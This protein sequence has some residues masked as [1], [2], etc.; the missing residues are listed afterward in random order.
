ML[1][2]QLLN[3]AIAAL[4]VVG[5]L[6]AA[7]D[8]PL[9][10]SRTRRAICTP[11]AGGTPTTD[12]VP[13]I[14]SALSTCGGGG[15]IVLPAD[16]TYH[17]NSVLDLSACAGCDIQIEGV[18]QF[19]SD[20]S[21]WSGRTAMI[22]L[23][24][25][26]GAQIRSATGS[27]V[28]DGAGQEAWDLFATNSSYARP[29]LLY[30][31]GGA[32]I[33]VRGLQLKDAPNVFVSINGGA[34]RVA[35][36]ELRL[37]AASNSTNAPKNTDG[38]DVGASTGVTLRDIDIVNDDDCVAFKP[39]ADYA[40]VE[41]ITCTGSHGISVGSLGKTNADAVT[42]VYAGNVTM[43]NSTKAAGIKTYPG[44]ASHGSAVV[45]NVTF[46]GFTVQ[47]C[48]YAFQVQSCYG[49]EEEYCQ[50]NPA[51]AQI[52]EVVVKDFSGT[53]SSKYDPTT[54]NINC[55]ADGTCGITVSGWNVKTPSGRNQIL[56]ANTPSALG[57]T[58][59]AGASG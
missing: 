52:G 30:I 18:V 57:I 20:T 40:T 5:A 34:E 45:K 22:L 47:N 24:N 3:P 53:T 19:A 16:V 26:Q 44:G 6:P 10:S 36:S 7:A 32:D 43:I 29:T 48:D 8:I 4:A 42:N 50:S 59:A 49:E 25:A 37:T 27:G 2:F 38:F 39:G 54:A 11:A 23:Q 12:D 17:A 15:T 56:C 14:S 55:G 41:A 9:A 51:D 31:S 13:A 28:I 46:E 58:C 33:T 21:Y 35:F 1:P